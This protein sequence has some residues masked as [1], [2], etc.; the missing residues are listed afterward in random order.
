[1]DVCCAQPYRGA[2][3]HGLSLKEHG[4]HKG[5]CEALAPPTSIGAAVAERH[6][7]V[8]ACHE[9]DGEGGGEL[10]IDQLPHTLWHICM[11]CSI[12]S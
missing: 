2:H 6:V 10:P 9:S 1:M 8:V 11:L 12:E 3:R 5:M 4:I 7:V